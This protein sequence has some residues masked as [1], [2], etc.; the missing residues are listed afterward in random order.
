[1]AAVFFLLSFLSYHNAIFKTQ[2]VTGEPQGDKDVV[3]VRERERER[4][5]ERGREIRANDV[6]FLWLSQHCFVGLY[7]TVILYFA[8]RNKLTLYLKLAADIVSQL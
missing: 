1:M 8:L 3:C 6:W 2:S 5:R 4:E 7:T